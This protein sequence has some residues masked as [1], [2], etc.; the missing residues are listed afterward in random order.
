M[1]TGVVFC[2]HYSRQV[3]LLQTT[4]FP[5]PLIPINSTMQILARI[6][7]DWPGW[8]ETSRMVPALQNASRA[9]SVTIFIVRWMLNNHPSQR[10]V[11]LVFT[12]TGLHLN[13]SLLVTTHQPCKITDR[14]H[15]YIKIRRV[16]R[17]FAV[18]WKM[19]PITSRS[20][21]VDVRSRLTLIETFLFRS[22]YKTTK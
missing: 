14:K 6:L 16:M 7:M 9:P 19:K 17:E 22:V 8:M 13:L 1:Y 15:Y 5:M 18:L 10:G 11:P 12:I 20:H 4:K 2:W 3:R 21:F